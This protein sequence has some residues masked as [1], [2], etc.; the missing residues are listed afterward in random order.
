MSVL[1]L[2]EMQEEDDPL[3][4]KL[5]NRVTFHITTLSLLRYKR[6]L[7]PSILLLALGFDC[8]FIPVVTNL[9]P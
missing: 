7:L 6:S 8:F 5:A 2:A 9:L 4:V 1:E 3:Y